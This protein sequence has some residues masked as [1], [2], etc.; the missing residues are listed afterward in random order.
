MQEYLCL[1]TNKTVIEKTTETYPLERIIELTVFV[2]SI[3]LLIFAGL[4]YINNV[5]LSIKLLS[6]F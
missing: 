6:N 2:P 1:D 5:N 3:M 4:Y